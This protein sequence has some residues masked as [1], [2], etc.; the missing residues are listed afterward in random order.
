VPAMSNPIG[1]S[2]A[3]M[4]NRIALDQGAS[5]KTQLAKV[6]ELRMQLAVAQAEKAGQ[7]LPAQ[8]ALAHPVNGA[9]VDLL[10]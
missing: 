7:D 2:P 1:I 10:I 4:V 5:L 3:V 8:R 9:E 6:A